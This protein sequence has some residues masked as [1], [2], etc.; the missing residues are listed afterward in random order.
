M[1]DQGSVISGCTSSPSVT[2]RWSNLHTRPASATTWLPV[3]SAT[4][5]PNATSFTDL[6]IQRQVI[7]GVPRHWTGQGADMPHG[8]P[9]TA[10]HTDRRRESNR[11]TTAGTTAL[12]RL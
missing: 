5:G 9:G 6:S 4:S 11:H 1:F 3:A 2:P 7:G 10:L 8:A 12:H